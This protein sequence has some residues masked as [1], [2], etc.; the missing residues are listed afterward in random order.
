MKLLINI[1]NNIG[2]GSFQVAHSFVNECKKYLENEYIIVINTN[3]WHLFDIDL[4]PE[5]FHFVSIKN[6]VFLSLA[7][8]MRVIEKKFKPEVVFTVFGPSYWRPKAPHV[9]GFANPYYIPINNNEVDVIKRCFSRKEYF[10]IRIKKLLHTF[11]MNRDSDGIIAE[12]KY[13][14]EEFLKIFNKIK[15]GYTVSNTFSKYFELSLERIKHENFVLLTVCKYYKHKNLEIINDVCKELA[16]RNITDVKFVVTLDNNNFERLFKDNSFVLNAG[17]IPP[18]SCPKLYAKADAMFLPTLAECFSASYPEAMK[19]QI[20]ILTS[21][22]EFAHSVCLDAALYFDP[23]DSKDIV[24]KIISIKTNNELYSKLVN[25]GNSR[26]KDF[27]SAKNRCIEYLKI[28][29]S[30]VGLKKNDF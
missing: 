24:D 21:D 20:P 27:S 1:S 5:N 29:N 2:G 12:T 6:R 8:K 23:F 25:N 22:L 16:A 11:Y 18:N 15:N 17:Y 4:F 28:C 13:C 14:T 26:V 3:V 10:A 9:V 30:L 19:S 7:K